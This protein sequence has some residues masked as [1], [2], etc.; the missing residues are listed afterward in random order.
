M[1]GGR[2]GWRWTDQL[3]GVRQDDDGQVSWL[4]DRPPYGVAKVGA[5]AEGL[6]NMLR[7]GCELASALHCAFVQHPHNGSQNPFRGLLKLERPWGDC[8]SILCRFGES[9]SAV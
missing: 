3:R 9:A 1:G 2:R 8:L 6:P 4:I 7:R 5:P